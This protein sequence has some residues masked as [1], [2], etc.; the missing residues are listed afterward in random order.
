MPVDR[1]KFQE[2]ILETVAE[3]EVEQAAYRNRTNFATVE[4]GKEYSDRAM[5]IGYLRCVA[6]VD[7]ISEEE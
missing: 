2:G 1:K 4:E 3:L 7:P 6:G 5:D